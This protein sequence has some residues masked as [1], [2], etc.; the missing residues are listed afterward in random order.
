MSVPS[1]AGAGCPAGSG[2]RPGRAEPTAGGQQVFAATKGRRRAVTVAAAMLVSALLL[3]LGLAASGVV[4][5][6]LAAALHGRLHSVAQ[7]HARG[8]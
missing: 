2:A 8:V 1:A 4:P 6:P 5:A 3:V 7:V